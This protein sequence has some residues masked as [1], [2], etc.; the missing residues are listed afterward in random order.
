MAFLHTS[1]RRLPVAAPWSPAQSSSRDEG[2]EAWAHGFDEESGISCA[3]LREPAAT[4]SKPPFIGFKP[5]KPPAASRKLD[6]DVADG[7]KVR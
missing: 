4:A 2:P 6:G 7:G 5:K 1:H 3:C